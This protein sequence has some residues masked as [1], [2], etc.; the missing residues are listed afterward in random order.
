MEMTAV[1][2][3]DLGKPPGPDQARAVRELHE[4][5]PMGFFSWMSSCGTVGGDEPPSL[6]RYSDQDPEL[7]EVKRAA[8]EDVA[9]VEQDDKYFGRTEPAEPAEP[10]E[11]DEL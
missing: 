4:G 5:V 2:R 11:S 1:F 8:A 6:V 3:V 9:R 7:D 10:A